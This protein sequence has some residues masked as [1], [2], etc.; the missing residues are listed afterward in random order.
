[1]LYLKY[2][3]HYAIPFQF[4]YNAKDMAYIESKG[5]HTFHTTFLLKPIIR[6]VSTQAK[7]IKHLGGSEKKTRSDFYVCF[8]YKSTRVSENRLNDFALS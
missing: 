8:I 3:G 5:N 1:M 4:L 2:F 6:C 7:N